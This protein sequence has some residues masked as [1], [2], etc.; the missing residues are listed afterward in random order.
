[1]ADAGSRDWALAGGLDSD[2]TSWPGW[3]GR[4]REWNLVVQSLKEARAG[5]GA[6]LLVEGRAGMGKSRLLEEAARAAAWGGIMAGQGAADDLDL[7]PLVPLESA[8]REIT[9]LHVAP[10]I[11]VPTAVDMRLSLLKWLSDPLERCVARGPALVALDDLQWADQLT[12]LAI[13]RMVRDLASYPLVWLLSRTSGNGSVTSLDRLYDGLERDG[14]TRVVMEALDEQAV[15]EIASDVLGAAPGPDVL[16][17]AALTEGNPF[18]LLETLDR[19]TSTGVIEV[20][21]GQARV[22]PGQ[23][24]GVQTIMRKRVDTLSPQTRELVQVAAILGRTITVIDLAAL[25]GKPAG[26]LV[27]PLDEAISAGILLADEDHLAFR[28]ELL[29]HAVI[30]TLAPPIRL[31]LHRE[32]GQMLL[33][34]RDSAVP[35]APHLIKSALPGDADALR[36]LDRAAREVLAFSPQT[37]V[38]LSMRALEISGPADPDRFDRVA[39]AARGLMMTG[40]TPEAIRLAQDALDVA[41]PGSAAPLLRCALAYALLLSGR[42][43]DAVAEAESLLALRDVSAELRG[44]A[45]S[46]LFVGLL[47]LRHFWNGR[48][49]AQAVLDDPAQRDDTALVGAHMLLAQCALVDGKV[50]DSFRHID[51]ALR[52]TTTGSVQVATRPYPRMLLTKNYKFTGQFEAAERTIQVLTEEIERL[53][54]TV[55]AAQP[56]FFR[57]CLYLARGRLDDAAAE[58]Q[59][60]LT[61]SEELG[62]HGSDLAGLCVLALVSVRRGDLESAL[63]HIGPCRGER[64][65]MYSAAWGRWIQAVVVEASADPQGA[66]DLLRFAYTDERERRWTLILEPLAAA[67]MTRVALATGNRPFAQKVVGTAASLARDNPEF[68]VLAVAAAHARGVLRSDTDALAQAAS[69][70]LDPW[71]RSS[72]AEDLGVVLTADPRER[73]RAVSHLE[74][75]LHGYEST[76]ALRDAARVRARLRELGVRRRHWTRAERPAS[77]WDSL[78]DTEHA[79]AALIA[80][81]LTN[82]QAAAQMFLSPHTVSTHLRHVFTKLGI[83]SRV[84][85]ARLVAERER[86]GSAGDGA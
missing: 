37:S 38:D 15:A 48:S 7:T 12:L 20:R 73:P 69:A 83:A 45:E 29:R 86:A 30:E 60:G 31:A 63:R 8:V 11:P 36:G 79:V 72:A 4:A 16:A 6:V 24:P 14:A 13:R 1:M 43:A 26:D 56:A 55:Q 65:I 74:Q 47:S 75:A 52:I 82:R 41:P 39:T 66:M 3:R 71:G 23:R 67:W 34:S 77:G 17:L 54:Q 18:Q 62:G 5:R 68:P 44:T 49:R 21:E 81:G 42:P 27:R 9:G 22:V 84:E 50:R 61:I 51:E 19:L 32:A 40:R 35:A 25:L 59:V 28:H 64:D 85:L 58:A 10:P 53:G 80:K 76:G 46:A 70:H 57:S 33:A 2:W 78:T